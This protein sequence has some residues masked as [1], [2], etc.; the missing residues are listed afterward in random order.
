MIIQQNRQD[1]FGFYQVGDYRTYSKLEA[2]EVSKRLGV[3]LHWNFNDEVFAKCNWKVEPTESIG[4]LY[5][6]RAQQIRDQYDYL[7][8]WYSGGADSA[9][10][11]NSFVDNDIKLDE[12]LSFVNY[13]AT[14]DKEHITNAEVFYVADPTI[15]KIQEKQPWIKHRIEDVAELMAD[16][17]ADKS[18]IDWIYDLNGYI[19]PHS[20]GKQDLKLKIPEWK[21]MYEQGKRV[22]HIF[23]M[24]KPIVRQFG[25][26]FSFHFWDR[27]DNAVTAKAQRMN[28]EWEFNELFYWTPDLP[29]IVIKQAH[30]VKKYMQLYPN[31]L[32]NEWTDGANFVHKVSPT[33][34]AYMTYDTLHRLIYPKWEPIP[35]QWKTKSL[36]YSDKDDWF[37]K[38]TDTAEY[39]QH[40]EIGLDHLWKITPEELKNNPLDIY[41]GFKQTISNVYQL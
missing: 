13:S 18:G 25:N 17:Y 35:Y 32:S 11:L 31:R 22:C 6:R 30:I 23:G 34:K 14:K 37:W 16:V 19:T 27:V 28:R 8:L 36:V 29:D 41:K 15:K 5:R 20:L 39:K 33:G 24:E 3:P 2:I 7:I 21:N 10:I 40:F 38:S 1:K 12:V 4:D 9:N 26:K